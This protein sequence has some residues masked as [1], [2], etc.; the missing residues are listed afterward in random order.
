MVGRTEAMPGWIGQQG[1]G[2]EAKVALP[3]LLALPERAIAIALELP[4][5]SVEMRE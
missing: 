3:A 4:S 5:D 2:F 1:T